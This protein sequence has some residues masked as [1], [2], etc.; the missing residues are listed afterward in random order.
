MGG[1]SIKK[2]NR[3]LEKAEELFFK[4]GYN[5]VSVDQIAFEAC[6]SKMTL[7]KHFHS[8]EDLFIE[9][10]KNVAEYHNRIIM[11][12]LNENCHAIERIE[13]LYTYMLQLAGQFPAILTRDIL[14]QPNLMER[15]KDIK[16][17][18]AKN[19]WRCILE[20]GIK[21]GEL[22]PMDID[23]VCQLLIGL[24][25]AFMDADYF[26]ED[27]KMHELMEKLFDFM[28]YGMLGDKDNQNMRS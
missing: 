17:T 25:M 11:E 22:R 9:I 19:M 13:A 3:L 2:L 5:G 4:Y 18:M 15:I 6:I 16:L 20:D 8:K 26:N 23:F 10:M 21:K 14:E 12:R 24:P 1:Q 27:T 7:Y 28:K